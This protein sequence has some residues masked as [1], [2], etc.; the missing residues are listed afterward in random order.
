M[1]GMRGSRVLRGMRVGFGLVC[2]CYCYSRWNGWIDEFPLRKSN[3]FNSLSLLGAWSSVLG[4]QSVLSRCSGAEVTYLF[5]QSLQYLPSYVATYIPTLLLWAPT[6]PHAPTHPPT[7]PTPT[8]THP[9]TPACPPFA[10]YASHA[11]Y[12]SYAPAGVA[13]LCRA[14]GGV[15]RV[16]LRWGPEGRG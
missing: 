5:N 16:G 13:V 1:C 12:A 3:L 11:S 9:P 10:S 2:Y 8:P 4:A 15:Y 7:T 6:H 14:G